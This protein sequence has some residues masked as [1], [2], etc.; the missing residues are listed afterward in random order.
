[1]RSPVGKKAENLERM[2]FW[3]SR[4]ARSGAQAV[5]FPELNISGY[6]L[7]KE[8]GACAEPVPGPSSD[9]AVKMARSH[10]LL[11][12]A[13]LVEEGAGG[14]FFISQIAA[15]PEGLLGVYRKI[16][17]G[18]YEEGAYQA[19][20]H[21]PVFRYGQTA[22]G[23]ELCFDGHFPELSTLLALQG[24]EVIFIP[25][26]SPRESSAQ[27]QERWLR[28]LAA[29]AYDNSVFVV[30]CNQV[31]E[32]EAGLVFSGTALILSPRGEVLAAG[33]GEGEG[34]ILADLKRDTLRGV[35]ESSRG[36]FLRKRRPDVY[37]GLGRSDFGEEAGP[38]GLG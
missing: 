11:V 3:V 21:C 10:N 14:G 18:P 7:G 27:K 34:T 16:H 29:R 37:R 38:I 9:A 8:I 24:A 36:F 23:I 12:L 1:M 28:Y 31:G 5:C 20:D 25:H 15:G 19:G 4:A 6:G 35:R 33:R 17:L 32:N 30:A 22:F 26:A 13:G 2:E